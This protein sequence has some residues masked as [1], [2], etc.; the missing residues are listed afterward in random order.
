MRQRA[1]T[2]P[3]REGMVIRAG[4]MVIRAG[5]REFQLLVGLH[6]AVPA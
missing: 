6:S 4:V 1:M 3:V 2:A 5:V